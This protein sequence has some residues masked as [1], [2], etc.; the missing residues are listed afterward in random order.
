MFLYILYI[1]IYNMYTHVTV[2][3]ARIQDSRIH[4][5]GQIDRKDSRIYEEERKIS[6]L[7]CWSYGKLRKFRGLGKVFKSGA[8]APT[9][10]QSPHFQSSRTTAHNVRLVA[11][12][13]S[14]HAYVHVTCCDIQ[15]DGKASCSQAI[16]GFEVGGLIRSRRLVLN[17]H[18]HA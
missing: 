7:G 16:I 17:Q 12:P 3:K 9:I 6:C 1:Q 5:H 2:S 15:L 14:D 4:G 13:D 18:A 10:L 11:A 8:F